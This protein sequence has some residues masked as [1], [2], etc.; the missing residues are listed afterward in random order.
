MKMKSQSPAKL[1][2]MAKGNNE[3]GKLVVRDMLKMNDGG[4]CCVPT[5]ADP[6]NL[7]K[8]MAGAC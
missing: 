4:Q 6:V 8:R 7:H 3:G 2:K 1:P 5:P